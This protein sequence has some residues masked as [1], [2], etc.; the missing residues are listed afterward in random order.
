MSNDNASIAAECNSSVTEIIYK[1]M[2]GECVE[3]ETK[4]EILFRENYGDT[5]EKI[6]P[7][8]VTH[9]LLWLLTE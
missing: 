4:N 8:N 9:A 2:V 7:F 3:M 5:L 6:L 1:C